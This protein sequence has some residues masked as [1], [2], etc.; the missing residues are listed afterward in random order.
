[1]RR[2]CLPPLP[3]RFARFRNVVLLA[4]LAL[5]IG[6]WGC[7]GTSSSPGSGAGQTGG[8]GTAS[9]TGSGVVI[10]GGGTNRVTGTLTGPA[11]TTRS[12]LANLQAGLMV[13]LYQGA[14]SAPIARSVPLADGSYGFSQ[15][16][17]GSYDVVVSGPGLRTQ[18]DRFSVR[19]GMAL[20]ESYQMSYTN[21]DPSRQELQGL[22]AQSAYL[23]RGF[24]GFR[25]A[26]VL[27]SRML[28][29]NKPKSAK[30]ATRAQGVRDAL[31][32]ANVQTYAAPGA[33]FVAVDRGS[34]VWV[35]ANNTYHG[36]GTSTGAMKFLNDGTNQGLTATGTSGN[37][38][39]GP[40]A[41]SSGADVVAFNEWDHTAS[42]GVLPRGAA[43]AQVAALLGTPAAGS[44]SVWAVAAQ[45]ILPQPR[46]VA[47]V[48]NDV[49]TTHPE[50]YFVNGNG[51]FSRAA[52]SAA[53]DPSLYPRGIICDPVDQ[54][55][56]LV[57]DQSVGGAR[58]AH[59]IHVSADGS[60]LLENV[61]LGA[62][63][64]NGFQNLSRDAAGTF[65]TSSSSFVGPLVGNISLVRISGSIGHRT[66]TS[67]ALT[68]QNGQPFQSGS[69]AN[70]DVV[71]VDGSGMIWALDSNANSV[72]RYDANVQ[73][74]QTV[75][76][77]T[78]PMGLATDALNNAWIVCDG[79]LN[80]DNA[81][82][83]KVVVGGVVPNPATI[84]T[85]TLADG[86]QVTT[87]PGTTVSPTLVSQIF[88]PVAPSSKYGNYVTFGPTVQN[89]TVSTV[90]GSMNTCSGPGG[91]TITGSFDSSTNQYTLTS[92]TD[93]VIDPAA[94]NAAMVFS[95]SGTGSV[96]GTMDDGSSFH[97]TYEY[98]RSNDGTV[99]MSATVTNPHVGQ[100]LDITAVFN[101]DGSVASFKVTNSATG[102]QTI[103]WATTAGRFNAQFFRLSSPSTPI[104]TASNDQ[105]NESVIDSLMRFL[106][107]PGSNVTDP[108]AVWQLTRPTQPTATTTD[109]PVP[110]YRKVIVMYYDQFGLHEVVTYIPIASV[111]NAPGFSDP[112]YTPGNGSVPNDPG[113]SSAS[114]LPPG[115]QGGGTFSP[116]GDA[117]Y[118]AAGIGGTGGAGPRFVR[119]RLL[120]CPLD[121]TARRIAFRSR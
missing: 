50:I 6:A 40:V 111:G 74:P 3:G 70:G 66:V 80:S 23:M 15:L 56:Y 91:A 34:V 22:T 13:T 57:G 49:G 85:A 76:T 31:V 29:S 120:A 64:I 4:L 99:T 2:S 121:A 100:T 20:T 114:T 16:P 90:Q 55:I 67:T 17:D 9:I 12:D 106:T 21:Q 97:A 65:Y 73:N 47:A 18:W 69:T 113:A 37:T 98:A 105:L 11:S 119:W 118:I 117:N 60:T 68:T 84:T 5:S 35:S 10:V 77:G 25:L 30:A 59:F 96:N 108:E 72:T 14:A 95:P 51:T 7:G 115:T 93:P 83:N 45:N 87:V 46:F 89:G 54:S 103:A 75:T 42:L 32:Q 62:Y 86:S 8:A 24:Y 58:E 39:G 81:V 53:L 110:G 94:V 1:M 27:V 36:S 109:T 48:L 41:T 52:A 61:T 43:P 71:T 63:A 102:L 78:R 38:A 33:R 92:R 112:P 104:A 26:P 88:T 107:S 28:A 82:L 79:N 44:A 116:I 101:A 19:S